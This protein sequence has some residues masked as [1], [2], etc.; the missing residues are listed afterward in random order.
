[1]ID[2]LSE[3][4]DALAR[5]RV[6]TALTALSVAWGVFM[7]VVLLGF[8]QGLENNVRHMF[9]DDAINSIW[10]YRGKTSRPWAG[11]RP[12]RRITFD[13]TDFEHISHLPGVEHATGRFYLWGPTIRY[14]DRS[15]SFSVRSVHP[16][17]KFLENTLVADGRFIDEHDIRDK[18]KV[19][20]IGRLVA[21]HLFR[22]ADPVGRT[23]EIGRIPFLVV[24]VFDDAGGEGEMRQVYIPI[25]TG[26]AAYGGGRRVH[27]IMFTVGESSLAATEQLIGEVKAVLAKRHN[28]DPADPTA[29]RVRNNLE[30]FQEVQQIFQ[31]IGA[32]TWVVGIG[33]L[34]AG[35]VGVSNIMLVA[36]RERTVEIGIRKALGATP[37]SIILSILLEAVLLTSTAGYAGL[38]AGVGVLEFARTVVPDNDYVKDPQVELST[39]LAAVGMLVFFG[40]LAGFFPAQRAALVN[41]IAALR[42][43]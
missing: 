8:G 21:D 30:S 39:A 7:L 17:H 11:H 28:Y 23:I 33:T 19:T 16:G 35:I 5:N 37:A 12:G 3:V 10:L 38:V 20:V 27:Q 40:A 6:R 2:R 41:P 36:V 43:E 14:G 1:M 9:R 18:R 26:Q 31:W 34:T 25:T 32:F 4:F 29:V 15:D 24:G 13:L 22:G 42:D